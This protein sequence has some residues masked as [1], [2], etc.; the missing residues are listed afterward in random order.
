MIRLSEFNV[1]MGVFILIDPLLTVVEIKYTNKGQ[2][3]RG[4]KKVTVEQISQ[5]WH[6]F[7]ISR[8]IWTSFVYCNEV[9]THKYLK[10]KS[11]NFLN[12][13]QLIEY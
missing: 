10:L 5:M 6:I 12:C 4:G 2:T 7:L 13:S 3:G 8:Q 1:N 9:R 11:C